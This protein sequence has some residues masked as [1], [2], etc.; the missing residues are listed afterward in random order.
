VS[1]T[2]R[3]I[4]K[5]TPDFVK[6]QVKWALWCCVEYTHCTHMSQKRLYRLAVNRLATIALSLITAPNYAL[7]VHR[8]FVLDACSTCKAKNSNFYDTGALFCVQKQQ[9]GPRNTFLRHVEAK[10]TPEE[11]RGPRKSRHTKF[12]AGIQLICGGEA[13]NS[14][15]SNGYSDA[16]NRT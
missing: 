4:I 11:S 12:T 10:K 13:Y 9:L 8:D 6:V 2:L 15:R 7:Q 1:S 16:L 3:A 14:S 5:T